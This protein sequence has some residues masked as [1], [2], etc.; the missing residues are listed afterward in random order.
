M[1][2]KNLKSKKYAFI[3]QE[4]EIALVTE[5]QATKSEKSATALISAY[6][7]LID[8]MAY[9]R[10]N[11]KQCDHDD[12]LQEGIIGF[13]KGLN[14]FDLS[15]SVRLSTYVTYHISNAMYEF[16]VN[17]S[18]KFKFSTTNPN[19]KIFYNI[20]KYRNH[21]GRVSEK[22]LHLMATE[23]NVPEHDIR[24]MDV[25]LSAKFFNIG[26]DN[27][28]SFVI[29]DPHS[30]IDYVIQSKKLHDMES[31]AIMDTL[32]AH[33]IRM[34]D[35]IKSRYFIDVPITMAELGKKYNVS[36]ERVRQIEVQG[37][38]L[39]RNKFNPQESRA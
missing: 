2:I 31:F 10:K 3:S 21:E 14:S 24:D 32:T 36:A 15:Q 25:H 33:D 16:I 13:L 20:S 35:I 37:I 38:T 6:M 27:E 39:L 9:K 19:K 30:E 1:T 17:N 5:Y 12:L 18:G 7:R 8:S 29:D 34:A 22:D 26:D 4:E 11:Y 23:L 28:D